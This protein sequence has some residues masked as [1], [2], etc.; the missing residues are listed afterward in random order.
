M[1]SPGRNVHRK[2]PCIRRGVFEFGVRP[3]LE[4]RN[5]NIIFILD[6]GLPFEHT[7]VCVRAAFAPACSIYMNMHTYSPPPRSGVVSWPA[8]EQKQI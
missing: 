2:E 5:I 7:C 3:A 1:H 8:G 4:I 6:M